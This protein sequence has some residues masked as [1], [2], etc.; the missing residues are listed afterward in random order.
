MSNLI[1]A[2]EGS[3]GFAP[4]PA[5]VVSLGNQIMTALNKHYPQ[6]Q[7]GWKVSIDTEGGVVQI[8]NLLLSGKMGFL[9]KIVDIDPEMKK[10]VRFAGEL[11]ERY[12]VSRDRGIDLRNAI[13]NLNRK[14][15]GE[16]VY[17][18]D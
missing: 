10:V 18:K 6:W 17:D 13:E 8:R 14:P 3:E 2:S 1:H 15:T 12:R 7:Q 4:P 5:A 9:L 11:F 16:A